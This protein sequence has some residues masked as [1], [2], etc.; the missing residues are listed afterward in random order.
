[1]QINQKIN[2]FFK[3]HETLLLIISF[4]VLILKGYT[5]HIYQ[6]YQNIEVWSLNSSFMW[7]GCLS[8]EA[9]FHVINEG[10]SI[11]RIVVYSAIILILFRIFYR[12]RNLIE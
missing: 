4:V 7:K 10:Q 11:L 1:M 12:S 6:F 3:K 5:M 9:S 8:S 2:H